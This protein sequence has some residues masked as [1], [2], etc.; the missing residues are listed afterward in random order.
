MAN[1]N[2]IKLNLSTDDVTEGNYAAAAVE[3]S[4]LAGK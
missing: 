2:E 1:F 3:V 4:F